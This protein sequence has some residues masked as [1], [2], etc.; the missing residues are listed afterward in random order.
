MKLIAV[1][2][3]YRTPALTE[4]AAEAAINDLRSYTESWQIL[5]VE[6]NSQDGSFEYL[7][8]AIVRNRNSD[9]QWRNVSIVQSGHNGGFGAGNNIAIQKFLDTDREPEYFY[10]L[11]SDA[12]PEDNAIMKLV[13][14]IQSNPNTGIVGSYIHGVDCTPHVTAFR[15][16]TIF[17]EF[18]GS[19]RLG[20]ISKLLK[21]YIVP[22]GIPESTCQVD[23]L[24]GA[25]ML[26]RT[27]VLKEI[28]CFDEKFFLYFEETDLCFRAR[29]AGWLTE[30]VRTSSVAHVGS[31]STGMKKWKRIPDYWLDSRKHFFV[32]NYGSVYFIFA[33]LVRIAGQLAWSIRVTVEKKDNPDPD[34]F[35]LDLI[36]HF[37]RA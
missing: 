6:N 26:V 3:N 4:K 1:I 22:M 27:S 28:G 7:Q 25:S 36:R 9:N 21:R 18:E 2:V 29:K 12:F 24:A 19:I 37:F 20:I 14:H 5:I 32:K 17:S 30:Y 8:S 15:F 23:W 35:T 34:R 33:T 10:F 11:N 16:P 13:T 31:A